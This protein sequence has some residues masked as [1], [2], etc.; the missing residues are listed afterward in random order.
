MGERESREE[1]G[2]EGNERKE[3]ESWERMGGR[4]RGMVRGRGRR[5]RKKGNGGEGKYKPRVRTCQQHVWSSIYNWVCSA[6]VV[7]N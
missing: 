2:K 7:A 4:E 6:A 1:E 5:G 3:R